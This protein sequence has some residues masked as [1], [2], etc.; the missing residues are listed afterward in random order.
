[1]SADDPCGESYQ[2]SQGEFDSLYSQGEEVDRSAQT[3]SLSV[4]SGGIDSIPGGAALSSLLSVNPFF[5][6]IAYR[7]VRQYNSPTEEERIAAY[8]KDHAWVSKICTF[9]D[10]ALRFIVIAMIIFVV[11]CIVVK[12]IFPFSLSE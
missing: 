10:L 11:A 9:L 8:C 3:A 12:A 5:D 2:V 4:S 7:A 1:M 6:Y